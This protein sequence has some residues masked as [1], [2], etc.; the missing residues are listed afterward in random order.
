ML[1][2]VDP[3]M[4]L[5]DTASWYGHLVDEHSFYAKLARHGDEV[6]TDQ[7]FAECYA[8]GKGR[9]SIPPSILMRA[10]LLA[11]HDDTSDRETARR[12]RADLDWKFA[13]GLPIDHP[14]F[15]P[16]T[17]SVFRSRILI[18]EADEALFR[19]V[20]ARAVEL[21]VLPR[22]ALQIIDSSAVLGAGA[23]QDTYE[24]LRSGIRQLTRAAGEGTLTRRLRRTL[25]R[26]LGEAKPKIDWQDRRQRRQ[27]LHRMVQAADALLRATADRSELIEA[28]SLLRQ[29]IDQDVDRD[30]GDGE[31]PAVRQ[32]TAT[33]RVISTTDPEM[34]HGRKSAARRFDGYKVH[35]TA[36][37][38]SEIVTAVDLTPA[39]VFDGDVAASLV[40]QAK[41]NGAAATQVV[42]DMAYG[43][44][45]V[46]AEVAEAGTKVVAKVPPTPKT[47]RF[48]KEEF[49]I[50]PEVPSATCPQGVVA[51]EVRA[52]GRDRRG[53][54]VKMFVFPEHACAACPVRSQCVAGAG[55]RSIGLHRHEALLQQG[56]REQHTPSVRRKLRQRAMIERKIDHLQDRGLRKARYRGRRKVL[57]Q[58][59]WSATLGNIKR[60]FALDAF[61][62]QPEGGMSLE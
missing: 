4:T 21:K 14:G 36:E 16:T 45:D 9:P 29:L 46:R 56:R 32:G 17:F 57:L 44:G 39:N 55:P 19:K 12:C 50:D 2:T 18:N 38:R 6:V 27:E 23:V 26:Y 8:A 61:G 35:L 15:H 41:V 48:A 60:L 10:C 11:L 43:G 49:T 3:Q 42:G 24:L 37:P 53:R 30:P 20:V 59:R 7:D 62:P 13:L 52:A 22:R 47:G 28:A 33:D 54:P 25:R 5:L 1:G 51:T 31:G 58:A 40:R 34:R